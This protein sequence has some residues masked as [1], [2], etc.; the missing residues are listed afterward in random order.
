MRQ[1]ITGKLLRGIPTP[2]ECGAYCIPLMYSIYPCLPTKPCA[3]I[4]RDG[5][6]KP[7]N[8]RCHE[9]DVIITLLS[10]NMCT[11]CVVLHRTNYS[12]QSVL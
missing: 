4:S 2:I 3:V 10:G 8:G 12:E 5:L 1:E 11:F 7:L 9:A 6:V